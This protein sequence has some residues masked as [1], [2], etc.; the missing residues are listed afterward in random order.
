MKNIFKTKEI[1]ED[2]GMGEF[3]T[4]ITENRGDCRWQ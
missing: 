4:E 2:S 1:L 3:T